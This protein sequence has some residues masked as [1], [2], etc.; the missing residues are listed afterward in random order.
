VFFANFYSLADNINDK[1]QLEKLVTK[2]EA[3]VKLSKECVSSK[4][5]NTPSCKTFQKIYLSELKD[6]F[7]DF[8]KNLGSYIELDIE[9]TLRGVAAIT[10]VSE[11]ILDIYAHNKNINLKTTR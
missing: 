11:A 4:M 7:A 10:S 2:Y 1:A 9:I 5:K 6:S 8:S 3:A